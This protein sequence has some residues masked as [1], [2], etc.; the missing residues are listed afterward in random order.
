MSYHAHGVSFDFLISHRVFKGKRFFRCRLCGHVVQR[1][2]LWLG[3]GARN[4]VRRIVQNV[5]KMLHQDMSKCFKNWP[6]DFRFFQ[7]FRIV[8]NSRK[9]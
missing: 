8:E 5:A 2:A 6:P 3:I 7:V 9:S 1:V 4:A